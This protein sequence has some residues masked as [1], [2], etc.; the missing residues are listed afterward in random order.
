MWT[1]WKGKGQ[2]GSVEGMKPGSAKRIS[3]APETGGRE[4]QQAPAGG[5][6]QDL[7][8]SLGNVQG[9]V[10]GRVAVP[11]LPPGSGGQ[12]LQRQ[13]TSVLEA[14]AKVWGEGGRLQVKTC[15]VPC[16]RGWEMW[17]SWQVLTL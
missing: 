10:G 3:G 2:I 9:R 17:V 7:R 14:G 16:G 5:L 11:S 4:G 8:L 13:S 15:V 6:L 12:G 1:G